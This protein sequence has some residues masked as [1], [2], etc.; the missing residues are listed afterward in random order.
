MKHRVG[1]DP[2]SVPQGS[3]AGR[4]GRGHEGGRRHPGG[5]LSQKGR[6]RPFSGLPRCGQGWGT[7]GPWQGVS[8]W[9]VS[10][11][12]LGAGRATPGTRPGSPQPSL[13]CV[14]P[15]PC[16]LMV[17]CLCGLRA[18]ERSLS[19]LRGGL[20]PSGWGETGVLKQVGPGPPRSLHPSGDWTRAGH[21]L[22]A[23]CPLGDWLKQGLAV[24]AGTP[25]LP[26]RPSLPV[27]PALKW[28]RAPPP[29][30]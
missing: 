12:L 9:K 15:R 27:A 8:S 24:P 2:R 16:L 18:S 25:L 20:G 14:E 22:G 30:Q 13:P 6:S 19:C 21:E 17:V 1:A 10:R 7:C 3:A 26:P 28:S 11:V 4:D 5:V 23:S 29:V